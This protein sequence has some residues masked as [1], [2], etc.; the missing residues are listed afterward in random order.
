MC[1]R[2]PRFEPTAPLGRKQSRLPSGGSQ[3][4]SWRTSQFSKPMV[5]FAGN[6][7]VFPRRFRWVTDHFAARLRRGKHWGLISAS[8]GRFARMVCATV[9]L[10]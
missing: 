2:L 8:I 4:I 10:R 7:S 9:T 3:P 5:N 1:S 6:H